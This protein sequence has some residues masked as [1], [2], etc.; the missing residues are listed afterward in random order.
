MQRKPIGRRAP[1]NHRMELQTLKARENE[2]RGRNVIVIGK[3]I[4][5][6]ENGEQ[7]A[8]LMEELLMLGI[9]LVVDCT[10]HQTLGI[11]GTEKIFLCAKKY[12]AH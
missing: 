9:D 1:S 11:G 3:E 2:F 10:E 12:A 4:Y 5:A 8:R 6:I 7:A